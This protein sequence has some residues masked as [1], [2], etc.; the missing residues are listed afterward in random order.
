MVKNESHI[1]ERCVKSIDPITDYFVFVDTGS[2]DNTVNLIKKL[3]ETRQGELH[4]TTWV[5]FGFNRTEALTF[6]KGKADYIIIVDADDIW[7]VPTKPNISSD[8]AQIQVDTG[9]ERFWQARF[10]KGDL[11]WK[12]IG[13]KHAYPDTTDKHT[14]WIKT[15]WI[16]STQDGASW[17]DK[18]KFIKNA[19]ELE[20]D[21][22][23]QD[24]RKMFYAACSYKDAGELDR[25]KRL[26]RKRISMGGWQEEVWYCQ[27]MIGVLEEVQEHFDKAIIE[28]LAAINLDNERAE[29]FTALCRCCR[30]LK[31]YGTGYM[32]GKAAL[33]MKIPKK[34]FVT[35][36]LYTTD[37][38]DE[39]S[40]CAY[41]IGN[42]KESKEMCKKALKDKTIPQ[43]R[44]ERINKNLKFAEDKIHENRR[45]NDSKK[46]RTRN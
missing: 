22:P 19:I 38:Y 42:F 25:A 27:Y 39:V 26:F 30:K 4:E 5:N 11:D 12:Y 3:L 37:L 16:K 45:S 6:A 36:S 14:E 33:K 9:N 20:L 32:F 1:L 15:G 10:L 40:V 13:V 23:E 2:A 18:N 31:M 8:Y 21:N 24:T 44:R 7:N 46:R 43:D 29:P 35:T 17:L 28:H 41:H 34:L